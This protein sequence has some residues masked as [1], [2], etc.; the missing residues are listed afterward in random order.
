LKGLKMRGE[1]SPNQVSDVIER[2]QETPETGRDRCGGQIYER[3]CLSAPSRAPG[4]LNRPPKPKETGMIQYWEKLIQISDATNLRMIFR[5][6]F[7]VTSKL[8]KN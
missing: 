7:P 5:R 8:F 1:I 4:L 3:P 2:L 6:T